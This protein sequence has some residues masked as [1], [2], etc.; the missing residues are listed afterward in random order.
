MTLNAEIEN[1][2][3]NIKLKMR[4]DNEGEICP[5]VAC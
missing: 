5:S 1:A 3:L 2:T 4:E